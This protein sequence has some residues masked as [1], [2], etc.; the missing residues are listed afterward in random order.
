MQYLAR[1]I[2]WVCLSEALLRVCTQMD[3]M[4]PEGGDTQHANN[5]RCNEI[6]REY[7]NQ[8]YVI[9]G[10]LPEYATNLNHFQKLGTCLFEQTLAWT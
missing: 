2:R 7:T 9:D 5:V 3:Q 4:S 1:D 8:P 10:S 6:K